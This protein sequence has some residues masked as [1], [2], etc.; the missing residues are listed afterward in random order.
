MILTYQRDGVRIVCGDAAE[1]SPGEPVDFI[2]TD[3]PYPREFE[4]VWS[5]LGVFAGRHL[6]PGGLLFTQLGNYQLPYVLD[7]LRA[8][9]LDY[10][11]TFCLRRRLSPML[12]AWNLRGAWAPIFAFRKP[13]GSGAVVHYQPGM[14]PDDL[15]I[16]DE[17]DAAKL[18]HKWGQGFLYE[19]IRRFCPPG[20]LVADPFCGSGTNLVAAKRL[21][22]RAFGV[23]IDPDA[24]AVA[25]ERCSQTIM[26][27]D[28]DVT[29]PKAGGLGIE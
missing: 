20:G 11:W 17:I 4:A 14:M 5:I 13:G 12:Y 3:P 23:D 16:A 29:T 25:A 21:G 6:R 27:F 24:C 15:E 9:G 1:A 7:T 18:Y 22:R 8:A 2:L 19:P 10:W 26:E 28:P